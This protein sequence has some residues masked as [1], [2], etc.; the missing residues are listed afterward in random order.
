MVKSVVAE[1]T[2][3][4][5]TEDGLFQAAV[6]A[7]VG[8]VI[9]KLSSS[10]D[11][12]FV[13]ELVPT[14]P[15]DAGQPASSLS[16]GGKDGRK[17][18]SKAKIHVDTSLLVID[19][20]WVAEHAR[21]VSRLLLG[22]ANV[23]GIYIWATENSFKTSTTL[24][25]QTVK[26]V[27]DAAP[28]YESDLDE[29]LLIHISY[30]PRR[31]SCRNCMLG[32]TFSSSGLK[33]CD[34]K[35][36][37]VLTSLQHFK[38]MYNFEMR[39]PIF[40]TDASKAWSFGDALRSGIALHAKEL[41][42]AKALIDGNLVVRHRPSTS[43]A[44]HEVELLLPFTKDVTKEARSTE[45]VMGVAV[46]CGSIFSSAYLCPKE[47]LSQ[48]IS[49]I[50]VDII[51]SLRSRLDIIFDLSE[52]DD[53]ELKIDDEQ[54]F[55]SVSSSEKPAHK[56][57]LHDLRKP[58]NIFFPRRILVPWLPGICICDYLQ[59]SD[60][61]QDLKD[62]WKE[63]LSMDAPSD[64]SMILEPEAEAEGTSLSAKSFWDLTHDNTKSESDGSQKKKVKD[65]NHS[66]ETKSQNFNIVIAIVVLIMSIL[67]GLVL[68]FLSK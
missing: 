28:C 18:G 13:F 1:E 42:E 23:I 9:G 41:N 34:F 16:E 61:I 65:S 15:N 36:G 54:K 5:S 60:S 64:L 4:Q 31:W 44:T 35:M 22:G 26:V 17:K 62:Q 8:L 53:S 27:A 14:P 58:C 51:N 10:L 6:P 32:P 55:E 33:P 57:I 68:M 25:W 43:H 50:K 21:Q 38:C 48:V 45:E 66:S 59:P 3:L 12:G 47:P 7:Q 19:R 30:S 63:L 56:L 20:D 24:L 67:M 46:I 37:K 2:R 40:C 39:L 29:R 49:D 52:E 11:K